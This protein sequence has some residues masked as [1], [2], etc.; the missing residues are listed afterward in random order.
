[1][2]RANGIPVR[3]NNDEHHRDAFRVADVVPVMDENIVTVLE[4]HD[5]PE[6]APSMAEP[7]AYANDPELYPVNTLYAAVV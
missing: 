4:L 7:I 5:L 1:V 6:S 3:L 2:D